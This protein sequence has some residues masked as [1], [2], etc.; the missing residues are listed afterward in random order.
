MGLVPVAFET[1]HTVPRLMGGFAN[2]E[3]ERAAIGQ[4]PPL[5]VWSEHEQDNISIIY[6]IHSH[7][8][9]Y[10]TVCAYISSMIHAFICCRNVYLL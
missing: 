9:T 1:Q 7:I 8:Y 6:L 5:S 2:A 3:R 10:R 4:L